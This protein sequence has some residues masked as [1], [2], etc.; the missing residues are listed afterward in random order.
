MNIEKTI[1][2]LEKNGYK[3]SFCNSL[4]IHLKKTDG[5][6]VEVVLIDEVLGF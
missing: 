3:V 2:S 4:L 6:E 1:K 5:C